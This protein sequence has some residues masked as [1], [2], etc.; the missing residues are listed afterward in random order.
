MQLL[1]K[2]DPQHWPWIRKSP[3]TV[4]KEA[5][6]SRAA[7]AAC[8]WRQPAAQGKKV[9]QGLCLSNP[10]SQTSRWGASLVAPLVG[11]LTGWERTGCY[12]TEPR[13]RRKSTRE[14]CALP[15]RPQHTPAT[16]RE[17][18]HWQQRCKKCKGRRNT[19]K[20]KMYKT[21]FEESYKTSLRR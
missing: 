10:C 15:P 11:C 14:G 20:K 12:I 21:L 17:R 4:V 5:L 19:A 3:W 9:G 8:P 1:C 2:R 13:H 7:E 16:N 6:P 18:H